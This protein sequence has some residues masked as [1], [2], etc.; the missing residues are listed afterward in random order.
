MN[1]MIN[2]IRKLKI[3]DF[4]LF[5]GII[6]VLY[7]LVFKRETDQIYNIT[8][9]K[10]IESRNEEKEGEI[11]VI[12]NRVTDTKEIIEEMGFQL[13]DLKRELLSFKAKRDTVTIIR[14]QDTIINVLEVTNY[15]LE[16]VVDDQDS[17]IT[18]QRFII[19]SK[20]TI[21]NIQ[22]HE[23]KKVK[24]QRNASFFANAILTGIL[25]FKK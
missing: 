12:E 22:K 6:A 8:P 24:K 1:L 20:D 16:N 10:K 7:L 3:K 25:I 11:K 19:E 21:I 13:E 15:N 23:I 9:I 2:S 4:L 14:I 17:I 5:A 18:K